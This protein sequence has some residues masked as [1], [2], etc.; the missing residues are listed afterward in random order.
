MNNLLLLDFKCINKQQK[1]P[2]TTFHSKFK[3]KFHRVN[4]NPIKWLEQ[5]KEYP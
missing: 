3:N 1:I 2:L 5:I 4:K